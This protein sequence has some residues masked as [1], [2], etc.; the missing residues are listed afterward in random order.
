MDAEI[1]D[2]EIPFTAYYCKYG[3]PDKSRPIDSKIDVIGNINVPNELIQSWAKPRCSACSGTGI[4]RI[5]KNKNQYV[6]GCDCSIKRFRKQLPDDLFNVALERQK[7]M[8]EK[9][10]T[11]LNKMEELKKKPASEI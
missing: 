9:R 2:E 11:M 3:K 7:K 8:K 1:K 5:T 10:E 4:V 6:Q